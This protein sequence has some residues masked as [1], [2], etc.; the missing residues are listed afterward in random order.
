[1][2]TIKFL[3]LSLIL[4]VIASC[5]KDDVGSNT[6]ISGVTEEVYYEMVGDVQSIGLKEHYELLIQEASEGNDEN[7]AHLLE[8]AIKQLDAADEY[9]KECINQVG[10]NW[11]T[12]VDGEEGKNRLLGYRYATIRYKSI[13]HTGKDVMLST[14]VVWPYNNILSDP[15]ANNIIIGC[16]ITITSNAERPSN[17]SKQDITTDVGMLACAAKSNHIKSGYENLVI[18][19]DYQGYGATHG[20]VH[21]YLSQ[22]ITA[23]QVLDGVR[24]GKAFY[25]K[26]L[27]HKLK[28]DWESISTGYSQ[29]GSVAMAVHRYIEKNNLDEFRFAGSVC[30]SGPYDPVATLKKYVTTNKAYMPVSTA[31]MV[32][33]MC[34]TN[35][36]LMGK[37]EA[38]DF[39]SEKFINTDII[40][41]I[42]SKNMNTDQIS[43]AL[44]DN[45]LKYDES[46]NTSL[47]IYR[48]SDKGFYPYRSN[49]KDKY[50]WKSGNMTS[51]ALITDCLRPEFIDYINGNE[52]SAHKEKMEALI[53]A[54]N[55]NVLHNDWSPDHPIILYHSAA[56][57]VVPLDN[58]LECL[59]VWKNNPNVM[60]TR[61]YGISHT[62]VAYGKIFYLFHDG[63]GLNA[64]ASGDFQ[65]YEFNGWTM[66]I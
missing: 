40:K 7:D 15:E 19:P 24:A 53:A 39:L 18:I 35:P 23:R 60:G 33:S 47:C 62:H 25:E 50:V 2:K 34:K 8:Y 49:N 55:D 27:G 58:Y 28:D 3:I 4:L 13:D 29:G 36:R 20:E 41:M 6:E 30:G 26:H 56:D 66:G 38:K 32:Y 42:E 63:P 45:S 12:G 61:Y 10:A 37:Y 64:V 31:M 65:G 43:D 11:D 44:L 16:H 14:L 48:D 59:N 54:L 52:A 57:E 51:Y 5:S 9:E 46:D 17:Y 1:M 21:P 22:D